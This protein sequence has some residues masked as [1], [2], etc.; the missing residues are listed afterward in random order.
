MLPFE[1]GLFHAKRTPG[2]GLTLVRLGTICLSCGEALDV[3]RLDPSPSDSKPSAL[4]VGAASA[5]RTD[6]WRSAAE[7]LAQVPP[8]L[9]GKDEFLRLSA[10]VYADSLGTRQ[11]RAALDQAAKQDPEL[12]AALAAFDRAVAAEGER[13]VKLVVNRWNKVTDRFATF[14]QK[15]EP[16]ARNPVAAASERMVGLT[17]AFE[18]GMEEKD[19]AA[20]EAAT[21]SAEQTLLQLATL[22]RGLKPSDCPFQNEVA[23]ALLQ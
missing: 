23:A 1:A 22:V 21:R 14:S 5:L 3:A 18:K 2:A 8:K 15:Y 7:A 19:P 20:M 17:P 6:D 10:A 13:R 4:F 16:L 9:R 12:K 11:A